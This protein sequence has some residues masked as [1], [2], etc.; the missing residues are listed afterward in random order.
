MKKSRVIFGLLGLT[1]LTGVASCGGGNSSGGGSGACA[2]LS[3]TNALLA[4]P[5]TDSLAFPYEADYA[6]KDFFEPQSGVAYGKAELGTVTDG[7]TMSFTTVNGHFIKCR[8]LGIN[9]PES[10][11]K[12]EAWGVKASAFAKKVFAEAVD[13]CLVNDIDVYGKTDN[14]SSQRSMTFVWYKTKD[15]KWRNYNLE[16]VEQCYSKSFLFQDSALKYL[17]YFEQADVAGKKCKVRVYGTVDP[18]YKGD[19]DVQQV[20]AYYVRHHYDQ[21]GTDYETGSSG[22]Y[23]YV[24]G[25]VVGMMGDNL[26]IRDVARDLEQDDDDPLE[27]IYAY[28]GYGS[29]LASKV[30]IGDLACFYCRTS[31][32]PAGTDNIQL[33]DLNTETS[34]SDPHRFYAYAPGSKKYQE[35][36]GDQTFGYDYDPIDLTDKVVEHTSDLDENFGQYVKINVTVR[37]ATYEKDDEGETVEVNTYYKEN[38]N[39][40]T[41]LLTATTIYCWVYGS[42][43]EGSDGKTYGVPLN[44]R[45][46]AGISP[47]LRASDFRVDQ[48][49]TVKAYMAKYYDKYQLQLFN[50]I[51]KYDYVRPYSPK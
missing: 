28:A 13:F 51:S 6:S 49:Y 21:I 35:I 14:T 30:D 19:D 11:A 27:C 42:E 18:D 17:S 20:T 38:F 32:F 3:D 8:L 36:V 39:S 34:S 26:V 23:L 5:I 40:S 44:L 15:G 9:T 1:L 16:C 22:K 29:S 4:T 31:K 33:T 45:I 46:D 43:Y 47:A 2:V 12:V 10:T 7:D 25:L 41:G 50:N 24:Q 48:S 37:N